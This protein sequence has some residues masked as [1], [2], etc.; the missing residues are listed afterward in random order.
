MKYGD[1]AATLRLIDLYLAVYAVLI[2]GA[3]FTLY[4]ANVLQRLP[5]VWTAGSVLAAIALGVLVHVLFRM[6]RPQDPADGSH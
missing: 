4:R 3:I 5:A 1:G 6:P 2:A